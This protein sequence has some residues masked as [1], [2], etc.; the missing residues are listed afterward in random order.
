MKYRRYMRLNA[1]I[2]K[3][4]NTPHHTRRQLN[5]A[6]VKWKRAAYHK[7]KLYKAEAIARKK[8][9][10]HKLYRPPSLKAVFRSFVKGTH[11]FS[12]TAAFNPGDKPMVY[13]RHAKPVKT[14]K[15]RAKRNEQRK[16]KKQ[17]RKRSKP[18]LIWQ[19]A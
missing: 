14:E 6:L 10:A 1:R 17:R 3:E 2:V 5:H 13:K 4:G 9:T 8:K 15:A 18:Q 19:L 11:T 7:V 12:H 16:N